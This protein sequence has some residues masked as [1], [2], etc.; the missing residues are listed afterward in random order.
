MTRRR[1]RPLRFITQR[2]CGERTCVP[3]E[4]RCLFTLGRRAVSIAGAIRTLRDAGLTILVSEQ[5]LAFATAVADRTL[6][7]EIGHLR[8]HGPTADFAADTEAQ[9][10]FLGV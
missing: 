7:L 5:S 8:W 1:R 4:F 2:V 6:V 9:R 3:A 10:D